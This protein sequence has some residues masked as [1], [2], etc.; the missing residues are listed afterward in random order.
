MKNTI[1]QKCRMITMVLGV[2]LMGCLIAGTPLKVAASGESSDNQTEDLIISTREEFISFASRVNSGNNYSGKTVRLVNDITFDGQVGNF[3]PISGFRGIFDGGGHVISGIV[4]EPY[5]Y[6]GVFASTSGEIRNLTVKD[7]EFTGEVMAGTIAGD[8]SFK[9]L[10]CHG[11]NNK[12]N[13]TGYYGPYGHYYKGCAGGIAG[14]ARG[15]I[16]NCTNSQGLVTARSYCGGIIGEHDF[17]TLV[18]KN[19]ANHTNVK[20]EYASGIANTV[21]DVQNCYNTGMITSTSD[22]ETSYGIAKC[23]RSTISNCYYQ[24]GTATLSYGGNPTIE[25]NVKD[26]IASEMQGVGF[27]K[28]LNANRGDS[29]DLLEWEFRGTESVYPVIT[30]VK[31][32]SGYSAAIAAGNYTYTGEKIT[33]QLSVT[34]GATVLQMD[35]DYTVTYSNN[36]EPGMATAVV[37]GIN[38]YTGAIKLQFKIN[39]ATPQF[40]YKSSYTKNYGDAS[41]YL[42]VTCTTGDSSADVK[43]SSSNAGVASVQGSY[44][45]LKKPGR[46]IITVSSSETD[47]YSAGNVK[48]TINVK[49]QKVILSASSNKKKQAKLRWSKS[50]G[51]GGY[52]IQ[53]S[54][55]SKFKTGVKTI[56]IQKAATTQKTIKKLKRHK[57]YYVRIR[58]YKTVKSGGKS[59]K[60][61]SGWTK[62]TIRIK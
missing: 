44:V 51:A 52:E 33:P 8:S 2:F 6:S 58:A 5:E 31:D 37:T 17:G 7:S 27:L 47:Y 39:K 56:T 12:V 35:K 61:Y 16:I 18:I 43:Y 25:K 22:D 38:R 26:M 53:Y 36:V 45:T 48:I 9:I 28:Q 50:N 42:D 60:L 14:E 15:S 13:A 4:T 23:V 41:F 49:P 20:G 40:K 62:K 54:T 10:N 46:T 19:C 34:N 57:K 3:T 11:I 59:T 32:L 1:I 55:S 29:K 24:T 30:K 21:D